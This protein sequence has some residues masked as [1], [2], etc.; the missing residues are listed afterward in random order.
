[1]QECLESKARLENRSSSAEGMTATQP[2]ANRMQSDF[3]R[4]QVNELHLSFRTV[5]GGDLPPKNWSSF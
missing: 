2:D 4:F 3:L 1:M 5:M